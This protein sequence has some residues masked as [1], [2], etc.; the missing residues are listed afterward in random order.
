MSEVPLYAPFGGARERIPGDKSSTC[1]L[2]KR[3]NPPP[4]KEHDPYKT[5]TA[6]FWPWL[7]GKNPVDLLMFHLFAAKR[8]ER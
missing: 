3:F 2:A 7:S 8:V 5:V 1:C 4:S 6:R